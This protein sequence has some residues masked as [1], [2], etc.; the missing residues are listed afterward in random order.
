MVVRYF[1]IG[2]HPLASNPLKHCHAERSE[3]S[4]VAFRNFRIG[5]DPPASNSLTALSS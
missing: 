3:A 2:G 4:A 5:G 1:P